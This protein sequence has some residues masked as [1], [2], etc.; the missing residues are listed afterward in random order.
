MRAIRNL[1]AFLAALTV[2]ATAA[3]QPTDASVERLMK[4]SRTDRMIDVM[5]DQMR[6]S[7]R[8]GLLAST[9]GR[10][11]AASFSDEQKRVLE[12]MTTQMFEL[13][14]SELSWERLKPEMIALHREVLTQDEVDA[15]VAFYESPLGST[16]LDK[17]PLI[18]QRAAAISQQWMKPLLPQLQ[19]IGE[20]AVK[21]LA[22]TR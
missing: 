14:R 10:P 15:L 11:G 22:A 13:M 3:A 20:E 8:Q 12:D 6:E 2:S 9:G 1:I 21:K 17:M 18:V 5:F 19:R 7:M 4:A 16:V